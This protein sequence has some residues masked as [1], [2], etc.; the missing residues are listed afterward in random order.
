MVLSLGV[1]AN[2]SNIDAKKIPLTGN[3][4]HNTCNFVF[5]FG[6]PEILRTRDQLETEIHVDRATNVWGSGGAHAVY[7]NAIDK[8]IVKLFNQPIDK[9]PKGILDMGCGN[10]AFLQ[11]IFDVIDQQTARGKLLDEYPLFIVG[12]DYNQ[13]A[14]KLAKENLINADIWAKVIFGD[15]GKPDVLAEKLI[16]DYDI[17]LIDL[18]NVRTFLDHNRPWMPPKTRNPSRASQSTGAFVYRGKRINNNL[19]EDSLVEHFLDWA[20][21]IKK[22]GLL[23]MELHT[24]PPLVTAAHIGK[25]PATAYDGT[26][27][28]ANV[29][30]GY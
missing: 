21:Y 16:K 25:T 27:S 1:P 9:Q 28:F 12:A 30:G 8:I 17:D 2:R 19:I 26:H 18:L 22:F 14:L 10:G 20:P 7:F 15:V 24:L 5:D 6:D 4:R 3:H 23:M 11:H 29:S 13:I